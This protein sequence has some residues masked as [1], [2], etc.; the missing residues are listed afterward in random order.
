MIKT[1]NKLHK[2]YLN[3]V[4]L[5]K[6]FRYLNYVFCPNHLY[7]HAIG[8]L[9][10]HHCLTI[11]G[12]PGSGKT[13]TALQLAYRKCVVGGSSRMYFCRTVDELES[14]ATGK[15]DAYIIVDDWLDRYI[16]YPST[17]L[18]AI[19]TLTK[20][21]D[22]FVKSGKVHLI[23]TAQNDKWI[24]LED[25]L[26]GCDMFNPQSL[27][28]I[29]GLHKKEQHNIILHHF[30]HFEIEE[31]DKKIAKKSLDNRIVEKGTKK[32]LAE[33]IKIEKEFSFPVIIDLICTNE[34]LRV[35]NTL[36]LIY[37]DGFCEILKTFFDNWFQEK[38]IM[39][40][41]SFCILVF[42][43]FLGGKISTS[44][45]ESKITSPLFERI[46][47]YM[48]L[49]NEKE[50]DMKNQVSTEE[51][52]RINGELSDKD[53]QAQKQPFLKENENWGKL[54]VDNKRLRGCLYQISDTL[55]IFQ[56]SSLYKFVLSFI[57][58]KGEQFFI[59]NVNIIVLMM[60]CWIDKRIVE[61]LLAENKEIPPKYPVGSVVLSTSVL[62]TLAKRIW[63]EKEQHIGYGKTERDNHIFMRHLTF[64]KM[65]EDI[66]SEKSHQSRHS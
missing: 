31:G 53:N 17:L 46:C 32:K 28:I 56:H 16:Y 61:K 10:L 2:H 55:F 58:E 54:L 5:Q 19:A 18:P 65:W 24:M 62:K 42:A 15:E 64:K 12:P 41:K 40:R 22:E 4:G 36:N 30:K 50:V 35:P 21:Y 27:L 29:K 49:P 8:T 63:S 9:E 1:K 37:K 45:F 66:E 57:K 51:D 59:E 47:K 6:T 25:D 34:R 20:F 33:K 52:K 43:A 13:I 38:D 7:E 3:F 11:I 39:E 14:T 26:T 60:Q 48:R 23:L 44:D